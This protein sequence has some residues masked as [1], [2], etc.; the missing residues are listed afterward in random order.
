MGWSEGFYPPLPAQIDLLCIVSASSQVGW[1]VA[2]V[3]WRGP[4][5][6][7]IP[8]HGVVAPTGD[9]GMFAGGWCPAC[10]AL[11]VAGWQKHGTVV[12]HAMTASAYKG[13]AGRAAFDAGRAGQVISFAAMSWV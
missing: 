4:A 12:A 7:Q 3:C 6:V 11:D 9:R 13:A 1:P 2:G 5:I 8:P 10:P